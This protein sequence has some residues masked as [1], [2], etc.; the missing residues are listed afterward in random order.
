LT[1]F[2]RGKGGKKEPSPLISRKKKEP[3]KGRI[4]SAI[5]KKRKEGKISKFPLPRGGKKA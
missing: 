5:E 4:C 2:C 3:E 1:C